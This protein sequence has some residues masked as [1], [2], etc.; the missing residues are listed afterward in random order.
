MEHSGLTDS[1][2]LTAVDNTLTTSYARYSAIF[3]TGSD[4]SGDILFI[5]NAAM[6]VYL[7]DVSVV[8][9]PDLSVS[10]NNMTN[11]YRFEP[12]RLTRGYKTGA[13]E[14][15][16][17]AATG[18]ATQTAGRVVVRPQFPSS[19]SETIPQRIFSHAADSSNLTELQ[20]Q[21]GKF[22]LV[23]VTSGSSYSATTPVQ[24]FNQ[25]DE[26][27]VGWYTDA[28]SG[29]NIFVGGSDAGATAAANT[30]ALAS[31]PATL[32]VAN[33]SA[34]SASGQ[35]LI[36]DLEIL[37]KSQPAEWFAEKHA[38]RNAAKNLNLPFKWSG[39][40]SA[41]DI[42]TVNALDPKVAGRVSMYDASAGTSS[43]QMSDADVS[44]SLMPILSPTKSMLYFPNS[45]PAGVEIYY[46]ENHQ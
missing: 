42:L 43:N 16:N 1:V 13:N 8:H 18:N 12:T 2:G 22:A 46:R 15:L 6:T 14:Q 23:K 35:F 44:G 11:G 29:A 31:D 10:F 5:T 34:Q 4:T 20:Y 3:K 24:N 28:T 36:D 26:L 37:A 39:T 27:E 38:K 17:F 9:R 30:S 25:D 33:N 41:G 40:L 21:G 19:T 32:Y 7:D 45:I